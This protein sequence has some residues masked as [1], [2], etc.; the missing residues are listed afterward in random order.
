MNRRQFL[1]RASAAIGAA[2]IAQ[3]PI[4][5]LIAMTSATPKP[6]FTIPF[7]IG[8]TPPKR[9]YRIYIPTKIER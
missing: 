7:G 2:Y 3:L 4:M 5:R 6:V 8:G 9:P 1:T